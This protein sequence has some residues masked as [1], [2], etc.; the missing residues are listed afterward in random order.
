VNTKRAGPG[1]RRTQASNGRNRRASTPRQDKLLLQAGDCA[2]VTLSTTHVVLL[3]HFCPA[4]ARSADLT[5]LASPPENAERAPPP[6]PGSLRTRGELPLEGC[7]RAGNLCHRLGKQG[8]ERNGTTLYY[9]RMTWVAN[10]GTGG[11]L[12]GAPSAHCQGHLNSYGNRKKV[13]SGHQKRNG[14]H[15]GE[16]EPLPQPSTGVDGGKRWFL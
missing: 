10:T 3:Y 2:L 16:S 4:F 7:S 6:P 8:S 5:S 13:E 15:Q 12:L 9:R 11:C 1:G 14:R